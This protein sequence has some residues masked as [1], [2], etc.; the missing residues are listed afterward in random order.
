MA[1]DEV[2]LEICKGD[3]IGLIGE[4]GS[5]KTTLCKHL[6][7]LLI[8]T[9]G[10]VLLDGRRIGEIPVEE[11]ARRVGHLFQ[12]PDSQL[13]LGTVEEEISFGLRNL[14][15]DEE[16]VETRCR[17]Y[18]RSLG[19][20]R[21]SRSPPLMLSM[22]LRRMVTIASVLAMEQDIVLLDEPTAWLDASQARTAIKAIEEITTSGRA[23]VVVSH[24]IRLVAE[25]TER[26][27]VLS[28]GRKVAD[29]N[30]KEILGNKELLRRARLFPPPVSELTSCL[31]IKNNERI[32][33][34]KDLK[35]A[36]HRGNALGR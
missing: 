1:L 34:V 32:I 18:T 16:D 30:T 4:N 26:C 13:F 2:S 36:L 27:I 21:Y 8:P 3:R 11:V 10:T 23:V 33:S 20:E 24:N 29:G 17:K 5:G 35:E 22:G 19:L 14:G 15:L 12:N 7:G 6:N 9:K 25:L 28:H 31:G